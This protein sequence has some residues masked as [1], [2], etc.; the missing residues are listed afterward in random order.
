MTKQL[1]MTA[2][3]L[4]P[5]LLA[6]H[7]PLGPHHFQN[8]DFMAVPMVP[9][10]EGAQ[11]GP[12]LGRPFS[13]A[14]VR[15]T[16]QFLGDG[17]RLEHSD[18]TRF[19]RDGQGRM[20]AESLKRVEI[21]DVI[22][23]FEYDLN[24]ESKTYK[25]S[26]I[27]DK[28]ASMLLAVVGSTSVTS[29]SSDPQAELAGKQARRR[30]SNLAQVTEELPSVTLNGLSIRG[31]RVTITIPVD[32]IGNNREMK[33]VNERWYSS[34]LQV[35]VKSSNSDPRFGVSTYELTEIVQAPPDPLLFQVP[36]DY[37]LRADR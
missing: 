36:A 2:A 19:Y 16:I 31:S 13:A 6:Q 10:V 37:T 4:A 23:G 27:P 35:L 30:N 20:R 33:V 1:F 17:T 15:K 14:E 25:K 11:T 5:G 8:P 34:D 3:L 12:V 18:T 32:A 21:F 7:A 24:P 22:A 29:F 9:R 26:A 28:T